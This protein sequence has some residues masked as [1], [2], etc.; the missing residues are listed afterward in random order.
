MIF[1][2]VTIL[3]I[4]SYLVIPEDQWLSRRALARI[5]HDPNATGTSTPEVI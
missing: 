4:I 1:G 5:G 2:F 3:A